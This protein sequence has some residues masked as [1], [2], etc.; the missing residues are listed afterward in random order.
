[1]TLPIRT[2]LKILLLRSGPQQLPADRGLLV[3]GL[4]AHF[5]TGYLLTSFDAT[6]ERAFVTSLLGTLSML[7]II[8][9]LLTLHG[10]ASRTLQSVTAVAFGEALLGVLLLPLLLGVA[11]GTGLAGVW[12][13]L[14]L[15]WNVALVG[16]VLRHALEVERWVGIM[17][18][19]GY[20]LVSMALVGMLG[21][22]G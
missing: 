9:G 1:M 21:G 3:L 10:K 14:L 7:A 18:A 20:L 12:S 13:L 5:A 8:H 11:V 22:V 2:L 17:F 16:H 4:T 6:A 15:G 19:I